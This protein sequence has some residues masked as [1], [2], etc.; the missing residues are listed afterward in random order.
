MGIEE[1][2]QLE[3]AQ[4][5]LSLIYAIVGIVTGS[6]IAVRYFSYKRVEL[7]GV[8]ISLALASSPWLAGGISFLTFVFFDFILDD[9]IYLFINYGFTG[10]AITLYVHALTSLMY[11]ES[12][13]KIVSIYIT[14]TI[15]FEVILIYLLFTNISMVG[16]KDGK[17]DSGAGSIPTLFVLF[18]LIS[19]L[20]FTILFIRVC[21]KSP[22]RKIQ[23]R[24]KFLII[25]TILMVVGTFLDIV[26]LTITMLFIARMILIT[27]L[28]FSYL[29][30]LMPTWVANKLIKET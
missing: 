30:W 14:L 7:L 13:K 23:W 6:I 19:I 18:V 4:G 1:L 26:S 11:P 21:L 12:L 3:I 20:V 15:I 24:G 2:T 29:A 28:F 16:T 9:P 10:L 27:R 22:D 8:G 17:F 5:T 25:S